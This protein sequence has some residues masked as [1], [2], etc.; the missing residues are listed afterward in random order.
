MKNKQKLKTIREIIKIY[1][2]KTN[3][4]LQEWLNGS[5]EYGFTTLRNENI[6]ILF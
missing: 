4:K 2:E 1:K 3:L 6:F 5:A